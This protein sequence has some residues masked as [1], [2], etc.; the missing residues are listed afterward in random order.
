MAIFNSS[1]TDSHEGAPGLPAA[2]LQFTV[3]AELISRFFKLAERGFTLQIK[4]GITIRE[5]LCQRFGIS[6]DYVDDRIQTI[7]L[8]G[9]PVDDVDTASLE[10]GSTL[11]LSAAMP[12]LVGITMRKGGFYASFRKGITYSA[13]QTSVANRTGEIVLKLFNMVAKELGPAFLEN[14]IV[15]AGNAFQNFVQHNSEDLKAGSNAI[16]LNGK[17]I[18]VTEL[19]NMNWENTEVMLQVTSE[20]K[21]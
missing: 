5:L 10:N 20:D 12:G 7:F 4:T 6:E 18:D 1:R 9:K 16:T 13:P 21:S 2:H 17:Q 11:A 8:D 19:L 15:V 14:G 3:D